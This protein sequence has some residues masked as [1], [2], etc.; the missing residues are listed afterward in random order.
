MKK[1]LFYLLP[2]LILAG[3]AK[4]IDLAEP[5]ETGGG[6][7]PSE[8][9]T[10][11]LAG[12]V[13]NEIADT[14]MIPQQD[15]YSLKNFQKAYDN[16][17]AKRSLQPL[18]RA[19]EAEFAAVQELSP[20][21]Y[22]LRIYPRSEEEQ[23]LVETMEDVKVAYFP[24]DYSGLTQEEVEILPQQGVTRSTADAFTEKSPY[25]VTYENYET[26]DGGPTGPVTFQLPILYTVWPVEKPLPDDLEYVVDYEVFLPRSS[27]KI[28]SA[29]ALLVLE[30]EAVSVALGIVIGDD[31]TKPAQ[32]TPPLRG[33]VNVFDTELW[34][35]VP[36]EMLPVHCQ[37][38]TNILNGVCGS[39]G[40][41][42]IEL[43]PSDFGTPY[44]INT[45]LTFTYRD[46]Y[47]RWKITTENSTAPYTVSQSA[48]FQKTP[49]GSYEETYIT[50]YS[51]ARQENEI[52][53]AASYFY[54][55]QNDFPK[56]YPSGGLKII[57]D[58]KPDS[59]SNSR[60]IFSYPPAGQGSGYIHIYNNG[61]FDSEVIGTTLHE[62]G[63]SFHYHN[64][65]NH[66][67]N[68]PK[69]FR[70]SFGSY[71]GWY[72][73][74]K[75]Y[76][77]QGWIYSGGYLEI[78]SQARQSWTKYLT[79]STSWYSPLFIDLS[80]GYNQRTALYHSRP[81]DDLEGV[82]ASVVWNIVSTSTTWAQCRS[83]LQS[84]VGTYYTTTEF[85]NWIVD[86]DYWFANNSLEY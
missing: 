58:N 13:Y 74:E 54:N 73:G 49:Y 23:W 46:Y 37:L 41:F 83:K 79:G 1:I 34:R 70:E 25:T 64:N 20:T 29:D 22:A 28:Q 55:K 75:Y 60:G 15:P 5:S 11:S 80:D 72:L 78:V 24:F 59:K 27:D 10:R 52:Q 31:P 36:L 44:T 69:I 3:C 48:T 2:A 81:N 32:L 35:S 26:T 76:Q 84:Y 67:R 62:I 14:W 77:S 68:T 21:H 47:N 6:K 63:H 19:Q 50:L 65:P 30:R 16:I 56:H 53:R 8:V 66:Y 43:P 39:S 45:T 82:P 7:T 51:S 71:S 9:R 38:G 86:F 61:S 42:L 4:Q 85:N 40:A 12:A 33:I 57:A 17:A 18:T